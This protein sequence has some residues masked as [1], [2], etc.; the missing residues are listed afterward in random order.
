MNYL[1]NFPP[2]AEIQRIDA[3]HHLHPFTDHGALNAR[4]SRVITRADGV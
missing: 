4:G 3:D 2:T 1:E